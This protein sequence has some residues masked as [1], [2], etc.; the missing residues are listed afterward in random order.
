VPFA[1]PF[2]ER[3]FLCGARSCSQIRQ[4]ITDFVSTRCFAAMRMARRLRQWLQVRRTRVGAVSPR[5]RSENGRYANREA[6]LIFPIVPLAGRYGLQRE[7]RA[8]RFLSEIRTTA[9][10]QHPH[11]LPLFVSG[12]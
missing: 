7:V 5:G 6:T 8:E 9:N 3:I 11:I 2:F 4:P 12:P 10:L 1:A